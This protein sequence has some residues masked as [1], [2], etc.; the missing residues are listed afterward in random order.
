MGA[1]N[2]Q[3]LGSL[4]S[5]VVQ[6]KRGRCVPRHLQ[7]CASERETSFCKGRERAI[8]PHCS[9]LTSLY[10]SAS[11]SAKTEWLCIQIN[12]VA[13]LPTLLVVLSFFCTILSIQITYE[14]LQLKL[15]GLVFW[16]SAPTEPC[17][18]VLERRVVALCLQKVFL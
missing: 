12:C 4:E 18:G 5:S 14:K 2:F 1:L 7:N 11:K 16:S 10:L 15:S 6:G 8:K 17:Q 13:L 3:V 9:V